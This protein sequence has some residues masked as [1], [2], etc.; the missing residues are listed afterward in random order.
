MF[1]CKL[2]GYFFLKKMMCNKQYNSIYSNTKT[3]KQHEKTIYRILNC[4]IALFFL[5]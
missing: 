2:S 5:Q 4:A 1:F 3:K